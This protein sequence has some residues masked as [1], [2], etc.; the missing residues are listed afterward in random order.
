MKK[1]L[2]ERNV[3]FIFEEETIL[4][5]NQDS[6]T[7]LGS[8]VHVGRGYHSDNGK[9]KDT[10][11]VPVA[12]NALSDVLY[13]QL[14]RYEVIYAIDTNRKLVGDVELCVSCGIHVALK[15]SGNNVW[16]NA[17]FTRLPAAFSICG[18][19]NPEV[20]AWL[21][22]LEFL[23]PRICGKIAIV[24][25]SELGNLPL[26]NMRKIPLLGDRFLPDNVELIYA[27][28]ERD[29]NS[30]LNKAIKTCDSDASRLIGILSSKP[31][32]LAAAGAKGQ[33]LHLTQPILFITLFSYKL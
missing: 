15:Y 8:L 14:L 24:V 30:P 13:E 6:D 20:V 33:A 1:S 12:L 19:S 25:D 21:R 31:G 16:S 3:H 17:T 29:L 23:S 5:E 32:W 26:Y 2:P 27:S 22:L 4:G 28:A 10:L 7:L 18:E 9:Y 11:L